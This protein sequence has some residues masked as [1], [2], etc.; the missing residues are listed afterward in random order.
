M[1]N[2]NNAQT[3]CTEALLEKKKIKSQSKGDITQNLLNMKK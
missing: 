2:Q 3:F 1:K